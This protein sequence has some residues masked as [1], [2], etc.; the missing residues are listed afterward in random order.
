MCMRIDSGN[1][2]MMIINCLLD[3]QTQNIKFNVA[4]TEQISSHHWHQRSDAACLG[5]YYGIFAGLQHRSQY[6]LT[7][8]NQ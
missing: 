7:A 6:W 5:Y 2:G 4:K 8:K 1:H 3:Q